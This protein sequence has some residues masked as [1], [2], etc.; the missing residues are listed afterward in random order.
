MKPLEGIKVIDLSQFAATPAVGRV[1]GE[2]GAE[3]IKVETF[4]GDGNRKNGAMCKVPN[5][6]DDENPAFDVTSLFKKFTCINLKS[7]EGMEILDRLLSTADVLIVNFREESMK[8]LG[9]DWETIHAKYPR[10]VHVRSTGFGDLGPMKDV[11]GFDITAYWSRG[12][13]LASLGQAGG[14]PINS[15]P[16]FGD[17]QQALGLA[18]ATLAALI[19][20]EK[21][22]EGDRIVGNLYNTALFMLSWGIQGVEGGNVYP[23]SRQNPATPTSNTYPTKD[24]KW[25]HLCGPTYNLFYNR[26]MKLIGREDL[27]DDPRYNDWMTIQREDRCKDVCAIIEEGM[28]K[29]TA[30]EWEKIFQEDDFPCQKLFDFNDILNDEQAWACGALRSVKYP[31]G[32]EHVLISLPMRLDSV[33]YPDYEGH[34]AK[35]LGHDTRPVLKQYGYTD[36]EID[37]MVRKKVIID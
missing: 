6:G 19:G 9:V 12:G 26:I 27:L 7:P 17:L 13:I 15:V 33:G 4:A 20:R 11:G 28:L 35:R 5:L 37:E 29:H 2:W 21:T 18:A 34:T 23:I 30:E 10:I 14:E 16:A 31:S 8:R 25:I 3:V 24:G 36:E 22:G 32:N 1:L